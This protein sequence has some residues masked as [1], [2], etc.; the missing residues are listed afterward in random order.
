MLQCIL[1]TS[2]T[3]LTVVSE[4]VRKLNDLLQIT[5]L[6]ITSKLTLYGQDRHALLLLIFGRIE[7]HESITLIAR[8]D[9]TAHQSHTLKV[10]EVVT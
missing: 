4:F 6:N 10:T 1:L 8:T 9:L 3:L 2:D 5:P 7:M